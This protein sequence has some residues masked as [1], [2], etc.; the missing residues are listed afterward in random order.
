M[1]RDALYE[2]FKNDWRFAEATELVT[3]T[4]KGKSAISGIVATRG[5]IDDSRLRF[6]G[7]EFIDLSVDTVLLLWDATIL[8]DDKPSGDKAT[9]VDARGQAYTVESAKQVAY[10]TQW[11]LGLKRKA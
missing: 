9:L 10:D 6:M 3:W 2:R 11:L 8:G 7:Q 1:T 4:P 5:D